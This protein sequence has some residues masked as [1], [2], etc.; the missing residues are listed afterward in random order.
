M[1]KKILQPCLVSLVEL[2]TNFFE[3]ESSKRINLFWSAIPDEINKNL[4]QVSVLINWRICIDGIN[5]DG[6]TLDCVW[7][8]VDFPK[9]FWGCSNNI[10]L[11]KKMESIVEVHSINKDCLPGF[12]VLDGVVFIKEGWRDTAM[13]NLGINSFEA[14]YAKETA[15]ILNGL[16]GENKNG[17]DNSKIEDEDLSSFDKL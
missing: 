11:T 3:Q 9:E 14:L 4:Y 17:D 15:K 12:K 1:S 2:L 10:E 13:L 8:H 7:E 6:N 16:M 5:Y